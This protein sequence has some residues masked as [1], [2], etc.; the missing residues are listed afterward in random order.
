[1][2]ISIKNQEKIE[3]VLNRVQKNSRTRNFTYNKIIDVVE[4]AER[5]MPYL[6]KNLQSGAYCCDGHESFPNAYKYAPEGTLI[7][8]TKGTKEWYLTACVRG[9]CNQPSD[10]GLRLTDVQRDYLKQQI[11][12]KYA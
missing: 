4:V 10:N 3:A 11:D 5:D 12:K 2:K 8:L 1:M 9:Y 7:T 6:P